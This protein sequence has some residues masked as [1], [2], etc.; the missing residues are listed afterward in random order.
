MCTIAMRT[1]FLLIT[2]K[3]EN[4][5]TDLLVPNHPVKCYKII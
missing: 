2:R 5:M 4:E 3:K 1:E